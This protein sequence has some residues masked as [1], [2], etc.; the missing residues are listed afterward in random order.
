M[1]V[2][3]T[4]SF[5]R[6]IVKIG[7]VYYKYPLY[8]QGSYFQEFLNELA[9]SVEAIYLVASRYPKG[10]FK[11]ARNI[12]IF[13]VSLFNLKFVGEVFFMI[14][15]LLRVIFTPSFRKI[16]LMNSIGPRGLL[17]G[18]YLKK[19][20]K[21]PLVCTIELL[22]E[23][24]SFIN[25]LAYRLT[26][27]LITKAPID[28]FICWSDYYWKNYLEKWGIS[29]NRV[30]IIPGGIDIKRYNPGV[31]GDAIKRKYAPYTPLIVFAKPLHNY[32]T[33]AAEIIVRAIA[34]LKPEAEVKVLIGSGEGKSY[35]QSLAKEL[36]VANLVHFMPP[37][38]FPEIPKYI[39]AADL[40]V[41]PY[42]YA[43]TTSRSLIEAMAMG[44]PIITAPVGEVG[45]ILTNGEHAILVKPDPKL[46]SA[47]IKLLLKD[48]Q[49]SR[50]L[51]DEAYSLA[52]SKFALSKT[53]EA[54]LSVFRSQI[55]KKKLLIK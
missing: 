34:L 25:N 5:K 17:A 32:N 7:V 43:P 21:I 10:N 49:F 24:G 47:K 38:P 50:K 22:N 41:L 11:K 3:T 6:E 16:D 14:T 27:F 53:V 51:G 4:N 29:R 30:V 15:V 26:R 36:G 55:A 46:V 40:I 28:R 13:W 12:K 2:N 42:T 31:N 39:A 33:P 48:R 54:T 45:K 52:S 23:R 1:W 35:I 19:I 18:W 44:K 9:K 8:P 20:Y 37:T